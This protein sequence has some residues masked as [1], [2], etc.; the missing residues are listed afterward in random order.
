MLTRSAAGR[1][2]TYCAV[3]HRG[4]ATPISRNTPSVAALSFLFTRIWAT[5]TFSLVL[6]APAIDPPITRKPLIYTNS[7]PALKH[8][9]T[10]SFSLKKNNYTSYNLKNTKSLLGFTLIRI[11]LSNM[12]SGLVFDDAVHL[13]SPES[14]SCRFLITIFKKLSPLTQSTLF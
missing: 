6:A 5:E 9:P 13:Y 10:A 14:F 12:R 11:T 3:Q 2:C 1:P 7:I 4:I 8:I